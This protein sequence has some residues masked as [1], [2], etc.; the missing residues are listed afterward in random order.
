MIKAK[1]HCKIENLENTDNVWVLCFGCN[2]DMS[3]DY[4]IKLELDGYTYKFVI[5]ST[6]SLKHEHKYYVYVEKFGWTN[7]KHFLIF[8]IT[9]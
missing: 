3:D 6:Y 5:E 4:Q 7:K 9:K 8:W 1:E 2:K